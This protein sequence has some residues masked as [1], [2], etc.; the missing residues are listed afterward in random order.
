LLITSVTLGVLQ[1]PWTC[2]VGFKVMDWESLKKVE[3][4]R[5]TAFYALIALCTMVALASS[6][7]GLWTFK[8]CFGVRFLACFLVVAAVSASMLV[9][10]AYDWYREV[11][12][13]RGGSWGMF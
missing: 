4:G 1:F 12:L 9:F 5:D 11:W 3:V 8:R 2:C 7:L 10:L 13:W 6:I